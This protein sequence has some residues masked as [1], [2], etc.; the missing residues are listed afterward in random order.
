MN[1]R[2]DTDAEELLAEHVARGLAALEAGEPVDLA[3]LCEAHPELAAA[4]ADALGLRAALPALHSASMTVDRWCGTVLAG[5]YRLDAP[6]GSG[7]AGTVYRARD[8]ELK[9]DVAVKV[10]HA[11]LLAGAQAEARF[12]REAEVLAQQEH[13]HVVRIY[14]RGRTEAGALWLVT[15]LLRGCSL[16]QV[17]DAAAAAM[18]AG[19]SADACADPRWL[20]SLLPDAPLERTFLRQVVTWIA[21]LGEGLSAAHRGGVF[22]RDVKPSNAWLRDDGTAVL[23]DF[24]IA[25]R[26]G[27]PA[28]THSHS[29]LGTPWYMAPEQAHG[30]AEPAPTLDVYGLS[31]TLY[32][33][34]TLHPPH[35]GDLQ[36]VLR[37]ARER[38]P[39]P[40]ARL[41]PG[42]P[43]DLQA[44]L[45]R[46]LEAD[47][48]RR[49][50]DVASL[51][52]D[53]RAFLDH[54]PVS[55]RPL[56]PV[57]RA[58]RRVRRRPTRSLAIASSAAAVVLLALV[59]P[60]ASAV[61]AAGLQAER[62]EL[63]A[64]LPADLCIEGW[65][66]Q[67][68]LV[69]VAERA[70]ALAMLDRLLELDPADLPTRLLRAS[71]RL[72][73][74]D[75]A[76][77]RADLQVLA[78]RS[79]Y[80][81]AVAARYAAADS[82]RA[83]IAAV[84][85]GDLPDPQL[86]EDLFVAGFHALRAR[87]IPAAVDLLGRAADYL[88][89]RDLRLLAL[90]GAGRWDEARDEARELEG[91][92]G[93]PTAR[94]RHTLGAVMVATKHYE[95]AIP[96]CRQALEL[97][98]DRHGPWNNLGYAHLRLGHLDEARECL[99]RA[100]AIRPWFD[101]S[102]AGLCQLLRTQEEFDAARREAEQIA[103]PWW[104]SW[105]LGYVD[106]AEALAVRSID[107]ERRRALAQAA[108]DHFQA[109]ADDADP[110][111]RKRRSAPL[112]VAYARAIADDNARSALIPFLDELRGDPRNPT[113][114]RNLSLLLADQVVD[115]AILDRL[116]LYLLDL[117]I[118][119]APADPRPRRT[120]ADLIDELR[121]KD[122]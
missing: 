89:A 100:V 46:G 84:L 76:G 2:H 72:D 104:R 85:L 82:S 97:R 86:P 33:L 90:L 66:D 31:A 13:P 48:R 111:N 5:R 37:A 30:R 43:R 21:Q 11:G 74:G 44:I 10:L 17:L 94:T 45:D 92:Y 18:P 71:E 27:D 64:R 112:A 15:E 102:R 19:P 57:A 58:L 7:A 116:R 8:L 16:Q 73:S 3:V 24:G 120:R 26:L 56:G 70:D 108:A 52:A 34:L 49:Y 106:V 69:P 4:V 68:L 95:Q 35:E 78:E 41:H 103:A 23:L 67:R 99:Q 79:P 75:H 122:R 80:L 59:L 28:T 25:T 109:V 9:R 65:P 105:E 51:V 50:P 61:R 22:H 47:P 1:P 88:P 87:D 119:L 29:V 14:D 54:R 77:A 39:V 96:L 32:H 42:L 115:G 6:L 114:L 93:R 113:Q 20:R 83:G 91:R 118:D 81:A 40:A 36:E 107:P 121:R 117:A 62:S 53:L 63:L 12:L 55:A 101:N 110:D 60:L 98:P 38:D